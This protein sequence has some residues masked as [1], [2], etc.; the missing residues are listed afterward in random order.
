[1]AKVAGQLGPAGAKAFDDEGAARSYANRAPYAP[2]LYDVLLGLSPGRARALDLGCGPGK[3]ARVLCGRFAAIDAVDPAEPMLDVGR[4]LAGAASGNIRWVQATAETFETPGGYDLIAAGTTLHFM[5]HAVVFPRLAT[6]LKPSGV[7]AVIDGD[8]P[9]DPP[10]AAAYKDF[11]IDWIARMGGAYNP[12]GFN[13]SLR[14]HE[15]WIDVAGR[16]TFAYDHTCTVE[17]FI[18][19][20]HSRG[21]WVRSLMGPERTAAFDA[22]LRAVL[23]PHAVAGRL[24]FEVRS[25]LLWGQPRA[26]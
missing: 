11:L 24:T 18:D 17:D 2:A 20:E 9:S 6:W 16:E 13:A 3:I 22:D 1:M 15:T 26:G 4:A 7:L 12:A 5:D 10:W 19:G 23:A 14:A 21:A 8:G 25:N